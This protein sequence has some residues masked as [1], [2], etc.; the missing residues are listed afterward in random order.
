MLD[1]P[2]CNDVITGN[3]IIVREN[4]NREY[5]NSGTTSRAF[6]MRDYP[7]NALS[8][9]VACSTG[10]ANVTGTGTSFTTQVTVGEVIYFSNDPSK[11]PYQVQSITSDTSMTLT[12]AVAAVAS[13]TGQTATPL[14]PDINIQ[15]SK[16][17]F[18]AITGAGLMQGAIAG[19]IVLV[20]N[21]SSGITFNNNT[22]KAICIGSTDP[23]PAYYARAWKSTI[24]RLPPASGS[25]SPTIR[26]SPMKKR[27]PWAVPPSIRPTRL[28][29]CSF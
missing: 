25:L 27:L 4:P 17:Y 29:M 13:G 3:T 7:G 28:T 12:A 10:S 1:G 15:V 21:G 19:R 23:G 11:T 18:E 9:T 6:A 26:S 20:Q 8:G 24:A 5:G 22:F 2:N 16:N 14:N